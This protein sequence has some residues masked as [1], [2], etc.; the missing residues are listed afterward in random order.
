MHQKWD[1]RYKEQEFAY[2]KEPNVFFKEQLPAF[3][4]GTILMPA[5]GEGRNG[6]HAAS[7]GW[8]V[9]SFDLSVEGRSKALQLAKEKGVTL[10]YIVAD[11]EQLYFE[12]ATFYAIGLIYAHVDAEKKAL[13]HR[14]INDWLKPGGVLILEAFSKAH[15]HFNE[16]D[17]KVGGPKEIGML[18]DKAEILADFKNYGILLLAEEVIVLQEG[19][20]HSG[21]GSVIRFVGKKGLQEEKDCEKKSCSLKDAS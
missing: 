18:Y 17:P 13:F 4:P 8:K 12:K 16:R 11:M 2:G 1:E 7:L 6:V 5:D 19:K 21:E 15:L 10:E 9:T 20:Y 14:K 3:P